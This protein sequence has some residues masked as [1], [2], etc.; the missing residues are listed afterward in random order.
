MA[1]SR[2]VAQPLKVVLAAIDD[3]QRN[4]LGNGI[5]VQLPH[6]LL[7]SGKKAPLS[8]NNQKLFFAL[9][10]V[11]LPT[12]NRLHGGNSVDASCKPFVHE[13]TR[14]TVSFGWRSGGDINDDKFLHLVNLTTS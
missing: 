1:A 4:D 3:R 12:I 14:Y 5:A 2:L 8:L 11:A 7:Q 13:S 10:N 9:F 6:T